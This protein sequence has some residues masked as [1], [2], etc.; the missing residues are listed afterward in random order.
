MMNFQTIM[1]TLNAYWG[2]QQC[3]N[4]HPYDFNKTKENKHD[5]EID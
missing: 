2:R 1:S 3:I 5:T 4:F